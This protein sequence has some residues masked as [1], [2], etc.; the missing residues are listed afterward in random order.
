MDWQ[1]RLI[2]IYLTVCN[3]FDQQ[4][5]SH[6]L[7]RMSNNK[8]VFMTD[9]EVLTIY[10]FG[11]MSHRR[12]I[13]QIHS[14]ASDHFKDWFPNWIGYEAFVRRIDQMGEMLPAFLELLIDTECPPEMR[15]RFKLIDSLPIVL[16]GPKRSNQAKVAPEIANK[17]YCATK[18]L[19]YYG[20]KL[21]ILGSDRDG[22]LPIPEFI[23]LTS[24]SEHDLNAFKVIVPE[25]RNVE[26]FCDKAYCDHETNLELSKLGSQLAT[27]VKLQK[28]QKLLDSADRLYSK[29]VSSIR[30][31]IESFFSWVQEKT[32]IQCAS[33]VRSYKGLMVHVFG[34]LAA[35]ML[36]MQ[37][38]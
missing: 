7:E 15:S 22:L 26:I 2:S 33:K 11:M 21:H 34:R 5:F 6:Y 1:T 36:M 25:M 27:P 28:G 37:L 3:I 16:A 8:A 17:G 9:Q 24:G 4:G 23:G 19:F 31:P 10:L 12:T 32:G 14:F 35:A 13:K 38:T 20:V 18:S 29:A 30:Q